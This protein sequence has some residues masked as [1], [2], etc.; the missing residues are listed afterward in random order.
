MKSWKYILLFFLK[1]KGFKFAQGSSVNPN[2]VLIL[3]ETFVTQSDQPII[4]C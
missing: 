1:K 4:I 3:K 2:Y